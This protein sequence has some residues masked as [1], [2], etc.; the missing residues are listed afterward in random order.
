MELKREITYQAAKTVAKQLQE[1]FEQHIMAAQ[2]QGDESLAAPPSAPVIEAIL[3][4]AFWASLRRE[5]GIAPR[6]S[7]AWLP[8]EQ[9]EQ[10]LKLEQRLPLSSAALTKLG[11]GVE[12][13]GIHLGVWHYD[14]ELFVWGATRSIPSF[15]FVVDVS[16]PGLIVVKH[17]RIGGFG[18]F[19]NV[20]VL[21][22]DEI[23]VIDENS[24]TLP[25]CPGLLTSLLHFA[26]PASWNDSVNVL[27]Q[28]AVS[29]SAHK[30]GGSLLVVPA[31]TDVWRSSI[32]HPISYA[33]EPAFPGLA[34]LLETEQKETESVVWQNKVSR[35]I[36]RIAGLTAIDGATIISDKYE[37]LAFGA[38][39]GR[40]DGCAAV[41]EIIA[42]EPILGR[43]PISMHPAINGGT[44][45]LSAAQFVH[46]QRD[47]L[48]LIAS[49]DGRFTIFS[50]SAC[51]GKV[52]AHRIDA[53]LI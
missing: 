13:P 14:G 8:P 21:K 29:M 39:I 37:L 51:E 24:S 3:D 25:D 5:E 17:R 42:T 52:Q 38:K 43:I 49:Q 34:A 2:Q 7:L 31:E 16:E 35:E 11:P 1:H 47:A 44:R 40:R 15:C 53:L 48:A 12:R 20:A 26:V 46:D 9:V 28:M 32:I 45:H 6:I 23:K 36:E 41:Q 50:W 30:H 27:I 4:T 19:A 22:G 10:P 18:K 33:I